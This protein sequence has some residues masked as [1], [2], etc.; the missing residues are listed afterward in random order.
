[1]VQYLYVV[2]VFNWAVNEF[3]AY[4]TISSLISSCGMLVAMP[5]F[6]FYKLPDMAVTLVATSMLI[7]GKVIMGIIGAPWTF[8]TC[9]FSNPIQQYCLNAL[10]QVT[11][12]RFMLEC[13]FGISFTLIAVHDFKVCES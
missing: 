3:S 1:M 13:P 11:F 7:I 9:E 2:R 12:S 8:Y 5:I 4:T 6:H 10:I